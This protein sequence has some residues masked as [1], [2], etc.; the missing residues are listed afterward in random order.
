MEKKIPN[1]SETCNP[2]PEPGFSTSHVFVFFV[3]HGLTLEMILMEWL[4]LTTQIDVRGD[5]DGMVATHYSIWR[6]RWYWWNGCHSLLKLTWEVILMERLPL[7]TQINVRGD[8][9]GTVATHYSNW[10]ERWYW[11]NGCHSLLKLSFHNK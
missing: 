8:I 6:E 5:I 3:F 9:D 10:R 4:P 11:W 1:I 2:K 7:T